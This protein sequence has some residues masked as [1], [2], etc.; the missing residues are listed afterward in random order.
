MNMVT[1]ATDVLSR[2]QQT[3]LVFTASEQYYGVNVLMCWVDRCTAFI[4]H[5]GHILS[6]LINIMDLMLANRIWL[7]TARMV[8][9]DSK[10]ARI[11]WDDKE[12]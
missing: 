1:R 12:A 2:P 10:S 3:C 6:A 5:M 11:A 4:T 9:Y 8:L 7:P